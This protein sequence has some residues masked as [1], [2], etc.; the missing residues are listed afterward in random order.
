MD[1][2]NENPQIFEY[3]GFHFIPERQLTAEEN[4]FYQLPRRQR[5][6]RKLGFCEPGYVYKSK[7]PYTYAGFYA[8]ATDR[9]C[10]LFRCVENCKLYLPCAHDLQEYLERPQRR[11]HCFAR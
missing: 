10:D 11:R 3:G 5:I 9:T 7:F 4:D 8:A 6:D 1:T 2:P